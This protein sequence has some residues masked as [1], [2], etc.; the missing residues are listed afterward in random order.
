VKGRGEGESRGW[1]GRRETEGTK[2]V[3]QERGGRES[4]RC[5]AA[6]AG[7]LIVSEIIQ[8]QKLRN[9]KTQTAKQYSVKTEKMDV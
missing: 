5:I 7:L 4:K 3:R 1:R 9:N 6:L 8:T 2:K